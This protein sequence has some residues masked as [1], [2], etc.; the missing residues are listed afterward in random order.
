[1]CD[2]AGSRQGVAGSSTQPLYARQ[3]GSRL[4]T[5]SGVCIAAR[6]LLCGVK[7]QRVVS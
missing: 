6:L 4:Y 7:Q 3:S 5:G 1:M 2:S